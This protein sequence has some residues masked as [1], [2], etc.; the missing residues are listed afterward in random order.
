M[1]KRNTRG[2]GMS[3]A[4][5]RMPRVWGMALTGALALLAQTT[6]RAQTVADPAADQPSAE[7]L[8]S[9]I[10]TGTRI[11]RGGFEAPTPVSVVGAERAEQLATTNVGD[12]LN[13][14]PA[15]RPTN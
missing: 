4:W 7:K 8:E 11:A 5:R 1:L 6:S 14:L 2:V 13:Q 3:S 15:F 9:V 12:L 10:V